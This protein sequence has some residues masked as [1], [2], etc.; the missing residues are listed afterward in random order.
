LQG[1]SQAS[2]EPLGSRLV[3]EYSVDAE[4]ASRVQEMVNQAEYI[5]NVQKERVLP[6]RLESYGTTGELFTRIKQAIAEQTQ[7]SGNES[8]LQTSWV[9]ATWF[10]EFLSIAPCLAIIGW[11][12]E[13]DLVLR[14]LRAFSRNGI[15]VAGLTRANMDRLFYSQTPTLLISEPNL[16]KRMASFLGC[17]TRRGYMEEKNGYS[18]DYFCSKAI[19]LGE[20]LP[21]KSM[22]QHCVHIDAS[23]TPGVETHYAPPLS[24][25]MTLKFQDQLLC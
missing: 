24:E 22:L 21:L 25:G 5:Q 13:G 19:Y 8:A 6:H 20:N 14:T 16:S 11:A 23:P 7:L 1:F 3:T 15:L 9:F 2:D 17:I 18:F 12:R 4:N 10:Q